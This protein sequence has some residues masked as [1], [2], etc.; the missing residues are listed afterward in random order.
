MEGR[1]L[2]VCV[3]TSGVAIA[4]SEFG[5]VFGVAQIS[6][7]PSCR[8]SVKGWGTVDGINFA[9]LARHRW[10]SALRMTYPLDPR[11][12]MLCGSAPSKCR[13]ARGWF[14]RN[15]FR[16][17]ARGFLTSTLK[18]GV[19]GGAPRLTRWSVAGRAHR[20]AAGRPRMLEI[21]EIYSVTCL[22]NIPASQ[23]SAKN[24]TLCHATM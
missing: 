5:G 17:S 9:N 7:L 12:S 23:K 14:E 22:E 10:S 1:Q 21:C 2:H 3:F 11:V 15:K 18:S 4:R 20:V 24:S 6:R 8:P 13:S 16:K 19:R